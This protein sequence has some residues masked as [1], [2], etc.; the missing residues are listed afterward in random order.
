MS[1]LRDQTGVPQDG[2]SRPCVGDRVKT[3]ATELQSRVPGGRTEAWW[4]RAESVP[5]AK[6][7]CARDAWVWALGWIHGRWERT[8]SREAES[9]ATTVQ[10]SSLFLA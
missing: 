3:A 4:R 9:G 5:Q 2:R 8:A 1:L 10:S 6:D 7:A